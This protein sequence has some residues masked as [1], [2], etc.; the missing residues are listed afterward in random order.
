VRYKNWKMYYTKSQGGAAGWLL[1]LVPYQFTLVQNIKRDPFEQY[2]VPGDEKSALAIGGALA[3]PTT[4]T[5]CRSAS[6]CG[7]K[8]SNRIRSFR[9]CK[10][11]K[12]T[13]LIRSSNRSRRPQL[14][15]IRPSSGRG[16]V[17]PLSGAPATG[18]HYKRERLALRGT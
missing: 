9:R 14:S 13:T 6:S 12:P 4:G 7:W 18:R 15:G 10:P 2:V 5:S 3:A 11:R 17:A 1:P 16:Q 8:N